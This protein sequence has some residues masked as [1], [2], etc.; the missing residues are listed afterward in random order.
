MFGDMS[1][2]KQQVV[3]Y[4]TPKGEVAKIITERVRAGTWFGSAEVDIE[5]PESLWRTFEEMP[6]FFFTKQI[7]NE[8][9]PQH[10][11]DYLV[12]MGSKR[13]HRKKLVGMFSVQK[14]LL[15]APLLC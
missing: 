15:Y 3:H 14:V 13:G 7:P 12:H 10:M 8:A 4:Q 1:C 5:F 11:K 2:S 9:V 6:P